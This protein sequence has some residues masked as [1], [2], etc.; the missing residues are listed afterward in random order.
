MPKPLEYC[1]LSSTIP[2]LHDGDK[3]AR[4]SLDEATT[5]NI[6][7]FYTCFNHTQPPLC[8]NDQDFSLCPSECPDKFLCTEDSVF[9]LLAK[10][11]TSKSTGSDGICSRMLKC[12]AACITPELC[13]L[14][15]LSIFSGIFSTDWKLGRITLIPNGTNSSL[16]S[17]YRPISV[18][19]IANKLIERHV[20]LIVEDHL[21]ENSPISTKQWG[22]MSS[23]SMVSALIR[24]IDDWLYALDQ[25]YEVCAVF[26]DVSK[27]FDSVP[28]LAL[29]SKL[30]EL[31][32]DPYL[33]WW[34]RS[35]LSNRS[36]CVSIDG[37][38]SHV[39]PVASGVPQG[40]VLGPLL[41]ILYIND[42][43]TALSTE[44]EMNM[45][46]DDVALY[47]YRVIKSSIDY[48]H[49]QNDINSISDCVKSKYLQFN[50]NK[51]KVMLVIKRGIIQYNPRNCV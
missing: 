42:V 50:T 22:F 9:E 16:P 33:L 7:F 24:V 26:F 45:F 47:I 11:D 1:L 43:A 37:V 25:G 40:S 12:I 41:F 35:Y 28:H 48:S 2:M 14:F 38:D 10:L 17:G 23:C 29:L 19:P 4:T 39:L 27:A 36:Q 3:T 13:R 44:S 32:L 18:L 46:A 8:D 15:N 49:L 31:G 20:K 6:F 5:L 30:S 21:R 51:C 34:I